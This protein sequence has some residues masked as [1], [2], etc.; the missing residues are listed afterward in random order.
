MNSPIIFFVRSH[1]VIALVDSGR[2][3]HGMR[4]VFL[5]WL[6]S[7]KAVRKLKIVV[8]APSSP[9]AVTVTRAFLFSVWAVLQVLSLAGT[10]LCGVMLYTTRSRL[11]RARVTFPRRSTP[12]LICRPCLHPMIERLNIQ[13]GIQKL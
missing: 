1:G 5:P 3:A 7:D 2:G 8:S 12:S 9:F 6:H 10:S 11:H 4:P 13:G